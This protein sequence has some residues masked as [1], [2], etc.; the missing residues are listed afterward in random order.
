MLRLIKYTVLNKQ[1][2]SLS[3]KGHCYSPIKVFNNKSETRIVTFYNP[4][5][6]LFSNK[7][8]VGI[9]SLVHTLTGKIQTFYQ[10]FIISHLHMK[11]DAYEDN[12]L[13]KS[14]E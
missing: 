8:L 7:F 9:Y 4:S 3:S 2:D 10:L 14:L 5:I 11:S 13:A 6:F 1:E 12:Y